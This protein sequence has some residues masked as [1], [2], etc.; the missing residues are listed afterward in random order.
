M[1][2]DSD[3]PTTPELDAALAGERERIAKLLHDNLVQ[4]V[5][6]AA[7]RLEMLSV[8]AGSAEDLREA[9]QAMALAT[10]QLREVMQGL[11]W[12]P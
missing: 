8:D 3:Q 5:S 2:S 4:S 6:I 9:Q 7:M 1:T 11:R 10:A 12:Q